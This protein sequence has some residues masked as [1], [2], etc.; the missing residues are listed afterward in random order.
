MPLQAKIADKFSIVRGIRFAR[1]GHDAEEVMRGTL[2]GQVRRPV[3]GSVVSRLLGSTNERG[4]PR[5]VALGGDNGAD[6]A[7]PSYLGVATKPLGGIRLENLYRHASVSADCLA[8]RKQLLR[9]F[10]GLQRGLDNCR[11]ELAGV[12]AFNARALEMIASPK[13]RDAFEVNKEPLRIR[14]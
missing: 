6:P 9:T 3:F 5:Y 10:D 11:E 13:V 8:D 12:D 4:V 1:D 7:A 2:A 14:E